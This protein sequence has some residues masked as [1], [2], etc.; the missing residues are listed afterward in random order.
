MVNRPD[1]QGN[2]VRPRT[3]DL[4]KRGRSVDKWTGR[5]PAHLSTEPTTTAARRQMVR[6]RV[7]VGCGMVGRERQTKTGF[8]ESGVGEY[9]S[10]PYAVTWSAKVS[11][12]RVVRLRKLPTEEVSCGIQPAYIRLIH[13]RQCLSKKP[14]EFAC[15]LSPP[16]QSGVVLLTS[17]SISG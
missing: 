4:L 7:P 11:L 9:P 2:G 10:S 1:G 16:P 12:T 5:S 6:Q 14:A 3:L 17:P 8:Q 13:R 15:S